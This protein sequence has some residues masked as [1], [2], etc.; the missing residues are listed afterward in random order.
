MK[1]LITVMLFVVAFT[2]T[3][4][5]QEAKSKAKAKNDICC[6]KHGAM[7]NASTEEIAKCREKMAACTTEE[8]KNCNKNSSC[9]SAGKTPPKKA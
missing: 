8:K 7:A 2:T 9:C 1:K 6:T 3:G 5:A 4:N